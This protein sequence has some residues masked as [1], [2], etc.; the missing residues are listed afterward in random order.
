MNRHP[1]N[2]LGKTELHERHDEDEGRT[3]RQAMAR[4][5]P[6]HGQLEA[7]AVSESRRC[8][9]AARPVATYT[10]SK[11]IVSAVTDRKKV[12]GPKSSSVMKRKI[13]QALA[14]SSLEASEFPRN[15]LQGREMNR[16]V[17]LTLSYPND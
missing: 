8:C 10:R 1:R 7:V 13:C 14:T 3:L 12:L 15:P 2:S 6:A 11:T 5:S 16:H 4:R 9:R 17:E